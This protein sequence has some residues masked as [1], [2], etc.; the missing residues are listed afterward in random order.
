MTNGFAG[1]GCQLHKHCGG[2]DNDDKGI[3]ASIKIG[4]IRFPKMMFFYMCD[5]QDDQ[6]LIAGKET[7]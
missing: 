1:F 6:E 7:C 2:D 3:L 5:S 4:E